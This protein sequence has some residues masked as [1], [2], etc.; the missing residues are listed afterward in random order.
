MRVR[1]GDVGL[2]FD[3]VGMG[4]VEDGP[5]MRERPVV[6]CLHGVKSQGVV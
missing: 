1:V 5:S 4:L 6:V 2:Y 3:V